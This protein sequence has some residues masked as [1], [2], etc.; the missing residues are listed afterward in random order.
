MEMLP[1]T[2]KS[3]YEC[4]LVYKRRNLFLGFYT[5][6]LYLTQILF[7]KQIFSVTFCLIL[8][9]S[10]LVMKLS[11]K[12]T[13]VRTKHG[14]QVTKYR[15]QNQFLDHFEKSSIDCTQIAKGIDAEWV[16]LMLVVEHEFSSTELTKITL[17]LVSKM[18]DIITV[19]SYSISIK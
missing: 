19:Y 14:L 18:L 10:I 13:F 11:N 5:Y 16:K 8:V 17:I 15:Q 1:T 3:G 4:K 7:G 12:R 6:S 9:F 2:G